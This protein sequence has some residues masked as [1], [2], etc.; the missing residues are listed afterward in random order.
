[1]KCAAKIACC[2]SA[3]ERLQLENSKRIDADLAVYKRRYFATQKIVLIGA[4]ES[5]KT[6]FLKQMQIIHGAGFT[7]DEKLSFRTQI[8]EN[9]L[10]GMAGLLNGKRELKLAWRGSFVQNNNHDPKEISERMHYVVQQFT[11]HYKRLIDERYA[12]AKRQR[13]F[14]QI[15]PNDFAQTVSYIIEIWNDDAIRETFD[16]KRELPKY[17]VENVPYFIEHIDRICR[18]VSPWHFNRLDSTQVT[19]SST[20]CPFDCRST[21]RTRAIF[22]DVEEQQLELLKLKSTSRT[23]LSDLSMLVS[24]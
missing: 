13:K 4:A 15:L 11:V 23:C 7:H 3:N 8:Y 10:K 1:M 17:F 5:G 6:T 19:V 18:Q 24:E 16:R 22:F 21:C 9:I 14:V 2:R 12:E 20:S